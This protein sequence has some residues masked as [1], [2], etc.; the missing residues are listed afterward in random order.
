MVE[1]INKVYMINKSIINPNNPRNQGVYYVVHVLSFF[2]KRYILTN[3]T[4]HMIYFL[5]NCTPVAV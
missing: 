1:E 3:I 4:E 5:S 2:V